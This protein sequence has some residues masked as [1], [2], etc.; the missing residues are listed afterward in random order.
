MCIRDS[1]Q[2][3]SSFFIIDHKKELSYFFSHMHKCIPITIS[4]CLRIKIFVTYNLHR[5][6]KHKPTL[7]KD[8]LIRERIVL[9]AIWEFKE[10]RWPRQMKCHFKI[11]ICAMVT[12][13]Q[14]LYNSAFLFTNYAKN[15]QLGA[16]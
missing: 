4:C 12:I 15:G 13:L 10:P 16:P 7:L 2:T 8:L 3:C 14:L 5:L 11:N 6:P 9:R 1:L